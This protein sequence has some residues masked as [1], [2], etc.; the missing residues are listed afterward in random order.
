MSDEKKTREAIDRLAL[1]IRTQ[2][3]KEGR[4]ITLED[5]KGKAREIAVNYTR[6]K[7]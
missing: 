2:E 1:R 6:K 5:S 4:A 3:R 7:N